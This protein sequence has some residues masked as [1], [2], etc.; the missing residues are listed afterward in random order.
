MPKAKRINHISAH[1][2]AALF[3]QVLL[4]A[5]SDKIQ[6]YSAALVNSLMLSEQVSITSKLRK[7][8]PSDHNVILSRKKLLQFIVV[9]RVFILLPCMW[10]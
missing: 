6:S 7:K 2:S 4:E 5:S 9:K 8:S 3:P 10:L 1:T